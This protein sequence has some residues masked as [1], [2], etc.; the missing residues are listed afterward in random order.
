MEERKKELRNAGEKGWS[1]LVL[2]EN[3]MVKAVTMANVSNN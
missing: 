1:K 2:E 3:N